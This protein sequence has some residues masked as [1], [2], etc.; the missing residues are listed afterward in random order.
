MR[1]LG[2]IIL[3]V[4]G[5]AL[6]ALAVPNIYSAVQAL[7][8]TGWNDFASYPDK[9]QHLGVIIVQGFNAIIGF[10]AVFA[11][12]SGRASFWLTVFSIIM[13]GGV[14][15]NFYNAYKAGTLGDVNVILQ[16][17]SGFALPILYFI[18]SLFIRVNRRG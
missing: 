2:R 6:I 5:V 14:I 16:L 9:M 18:G 3:L 15:W 13:I 7:N 12:F 17:A 1:T 10:T 11:C 4:V 8:E